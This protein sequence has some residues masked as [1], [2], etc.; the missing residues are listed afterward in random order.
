VDPA[1]VR[2][3]VR[4]GLV[5]LQGRVGLATQIPLLVHL[6]EGVDGVVGVDHCVDFEVDDRPDRTLASYP[7]LH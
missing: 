3:Q 6:A 2:V 7:Y 4:A 1:R 5:S